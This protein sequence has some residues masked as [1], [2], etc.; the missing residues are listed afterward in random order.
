VGRLSPSGDDTLAYKAQ[1]HHYRQ[2][3][4]YIGKFWD[5]KIVGKLFIGKMGKLI[6]KKIYYLNFKL[7]N[8][9]KI[10]KI[11]LGNLIYN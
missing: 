9:Y 3:G 5:G 11:F 2:V 6:Q 1:L 4:K 10:K 8:Q 7:Y